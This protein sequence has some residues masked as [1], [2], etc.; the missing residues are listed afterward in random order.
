MDESEKFDLAS[1]FFYFRGFFPVG[2]KKGKKIDP[3]YQGR[4]EKV[5]PLRR[6]Q[7]GRKTSPNKSCLEQFCRLISFN[8]NNLTLLLLYTTQNICQV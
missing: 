2:V 5:C 7:L 1:G 8:D 4:R 3:F 6:H